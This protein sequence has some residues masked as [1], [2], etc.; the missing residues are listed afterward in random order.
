[1]LLLGRGER[2]LR[3]GRVREKAR[4]ERVRRE[5]VGIG[6]GA[7]QT[8]RARVIERRRRLAPLRGDTTPPKAIILTP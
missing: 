2:V 4:T 3:V 7:A 6:T 5:G 1:M 8:V